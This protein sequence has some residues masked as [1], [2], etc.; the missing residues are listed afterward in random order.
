[1][2]RGQHRARPPLLG[3]GFIGAALRLGVYLAVAMAA[4]GGYLMLL[5]S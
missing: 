2:S 5:P 4:A 3:E 1:V